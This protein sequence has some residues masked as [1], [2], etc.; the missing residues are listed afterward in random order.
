[1]DRDR[2]QLATATFANETPSGWQ[3][4]T[5]A[6]PVPI[7]AGT[8]YVA[9]YLAPNGHYSVTAPGFGRR[10]FDNAPLH[11]LPNGGVRNGVYA[12][13]PSRSRRASSTPPTTWSTSCSEPGPSHAG[14]PCHRAA[15]RCLH[16]RAGRVRRLLVDARAGDGRE[17]PSQL[18]GAVEPRSTRARR[19][20]VTAAKSAIYRQG[21][22]AYKGSKRRRRRRARTRS[23]RPTA[24]STARHR[25]KNEQRGTGV[26]PLNPCTLVTRAEAGAILG[27]PIA[28]L[29]QA[30]Q[31][32][33]CIY[34]AGKA[35]ALITMSIQLT[36]F[37]PKKQSAKNVTRVT[38]RG[39]K[40]YCVNDHG[41]A[42]LVPLAAG[43]VLHVS[44]PC[45]IASGFASKAL[46]R[47]YP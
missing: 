13:G 41:L 6:T 30:P 28:G 20:S 10:P 12:Y 25:A 19:R 17:R 22:R 32:P 46:A 37:D 23:A 24:R 14:A 27:R 1:M 38:L 45:P 11:A 9:S 26:E 43:H 35:R 5:F 40:A 39:H 31:G 2:H 15:R 36:P 29:H 33:T 42:M 3:A 34:E 7:T 16:R 18:P 21:R 8:T 44:A 4:V 47:L